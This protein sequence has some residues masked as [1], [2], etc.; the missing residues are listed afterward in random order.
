MQG[1][2]PLALANFVKV[3]LPA[4]ARSLAHLTHTYIFPTYHLLALSARWQRQTKKDRDLSE[5]AV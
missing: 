5:N 2:L 4:S 1:L 3:V